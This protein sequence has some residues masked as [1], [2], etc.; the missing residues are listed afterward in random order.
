MDDLERT[1]DL[2]KRGKFSRAQLYGELVAAEHDQSMAKRDQHG[3]KT[4][5]EK[6][7]DDVR[8]MYPHMKES[9]V[10]DHVQSRSPELWEEHKRVNKLGG[11]GDL[12]QPR[13]QVQQAGDEHPQAARSGR[14]QPSRAPQWE[15]DHSGSPPTTPEPEVEHMSEKPAIKIIADMH[16]HTGL[17]PE[18]LVTILKSLPI[19]RRLLGVAAQEVR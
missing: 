14:K 7:C 8:R 19:G 10:H 3:L 2:A 17:E 11:G 13:H 9:A 6:E 12:P 16:R 1:I 4:D 5:Y 15:S 18:R